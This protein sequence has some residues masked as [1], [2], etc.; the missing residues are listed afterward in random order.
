LQEESEFFAGRIRILT[1]AATA[2]SLRIEMPEFIKYF[3]YVIHA[4]IVPEAAGG[5][6]IVPFR[7]FAQVPRVDAGVSE[8][9][10]RLGGFQKGTREPAPG[11]LTRRIRNLP[12]RATGG[13]HE[14]G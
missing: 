6:W 7:W 8:N 13:Y 10:K 5:T 14:D 4:C 12:Y 1:V 11:C 2:Q 3:D 9:A